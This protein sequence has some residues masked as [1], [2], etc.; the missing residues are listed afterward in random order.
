MCVGV[1]GSGPVVQ[2][3]VNLKRCVGYAC[4]Y[5]YLKSAVATGT[6]SSGGSGSGSGSG[7]GYYSGT[8]YSGSG[9]YSGSSY[10][11]GSGV[12]AGG[13][14]NGTVIYGTLMAAAGTARVLPPPTGSG[15]GAGSGSGGGMASWPMLTGAYEYDSVYITSKALPDSDRTMYA[16]Y[17]NGRG[18]WH[19]SDGSG[20][21]LVYPLPLHGMCLL[22]PLPLHGMPRSRCL[23]VPSLPL[24]L[25]I[26][27]SF[28]LPPTLISLSGPC[29][30]SDMKSPMQS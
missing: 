17:Y 25:S 26:L 9:Y 5:I 20:M 24:S 13:S 7:S 28:L 11:S 22:Y 15:S 27:A 1:Q 23:V 18:A 4:S 8:E 12:S 6:S 16:N 29:A 2:V 19:T 3:S 14:V 10:P 21:C 30:V